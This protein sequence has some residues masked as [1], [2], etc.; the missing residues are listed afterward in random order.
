MLP[1][2]EYSNAA[3]F[4]RD[5]WEEKKRRNPAFTLRAWAK[6]LGMESHG[7]LHLILSG[8]RALPKKHVPLFIENLGLTPR[9]GLYFE[10]LVD[11]HRARSH[12]QKEF[13]LNRL[14]E[15]SN[16]GEVR[17]FEVESFKYLANPI[18]TLILEMTALRG[19]R[20]DP[21]WIQKR[22][23][24][25]ATEKDVESAIER[26]IA[27]GL[28]SEGKDGV[29]AKTNHHLSTR[30]DISDRGI[31]E[32]HRNISQVA[33]AA[34]D[35]QS[36]AEREFGSYSF[37]LKRSAL[38]LAKGAIREFFKDFF[39]RFEAAA[40]EGEE[41]YQINVQLFGMTEDKKGEVK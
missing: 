29:L 35:Q 28:L 16:R 33:Q 12:E 5:T 31:R 40:G 18:H 19:F 32:Y 2:F 10:T 26:L 11:L 27:L 39:A 17:M 38:P 21:K 25:V 36:L 6:H 37:N 20:F 23:K 9:E 4:L 41:T 8:Q 14:T 1:V 3:A 7:P 24:I 15:L 30:P 13:Y 34:L 22:L